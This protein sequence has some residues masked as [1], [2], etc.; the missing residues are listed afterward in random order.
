MA[1]LNNL[2]VAANVLQVVGF[3]ADTVFSIGQG[4]YELLDKARLA[5]QTIALLLHQ[6]Q[7]LLSV[8]ALVRIVIDEHQQSPFAHEDGHGLPN[9]QTLLLLIEQD[10]RH[11]KSILESTAGPS[12]FGW[13]SNLHTSFWWALKD[14]DVVDARQRLSQYTQQL[15]AALSAVGR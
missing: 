6:L 8:V 7:A 11:L 9:V 5:S 10:F 4:L 1:A 14:R 13:L 2:S 15:S 12:R 3:H